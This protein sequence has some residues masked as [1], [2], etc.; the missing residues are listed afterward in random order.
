VACRFTVGDLEGREALSREQDPCVADDLAALIC[1]RSASC[2]PRFRF[3]TVPEALTI[4]H[5]TPGSLSRN[6]ASRI[7]ALERIIDK[8]S[9]YRSDRRLRSRVIVRLGRLHAE[10]SDGDAWRRCMRE[11]LRL[12]PVN[13]RA[14]LMLTAGAVFGPQVGVQTATRWNAV[15]RW[16]RSRR[17]ADP[18]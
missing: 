13:A 12:W 10:A 2:G 17:R 9:E 6:Q 16:A 18:C 8:H 4:V 3:L 14:M 5:V 7:A 1:R 11:A 15:L